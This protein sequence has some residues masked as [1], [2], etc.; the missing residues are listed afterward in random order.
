MPS[1]Q[2]IRDKAGY[3][4][5][6]AGL[7]VCVMELCDALLRLEFNTAY[8]LALLG[9]GEYCVPVP[10]M[11]DGHEPMHTWEKQLHS[12]TRHALLALRGD[13]VDLV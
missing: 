6:A 12:R 5:S 13:P 2:E 1:F 9:M 10:K 3:V 7:A 4:G 11:S 8:Q